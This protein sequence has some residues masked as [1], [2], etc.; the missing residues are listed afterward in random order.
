ML[1]FFNN[2]LD[3]KVNKKDNS[4]IF[5]CEVDITIRVLVHEV[6]H[7]PYCAGRFCLVNETVFKGGDVSFAWF[8]LNLSF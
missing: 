8:E 5:L 2:F 3:R 7:L 4:G 6:E 1:V